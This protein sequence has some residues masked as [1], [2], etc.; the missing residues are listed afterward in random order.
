MIYNSPL[1]D[2]VIDR[3]GIDALFYAAYQAS[4]T[5]RG[6]KDI[7]TVEEEELGQEMC[8][9]IVEYLWAELAHKIYYDT[10]EWMLP[11][12]ELRDMAEHTLD[13]FNR[14]GAEYPN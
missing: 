10:G 6:P 13:V 5:I 11:A 3:I 14:Y 7:L 1:A 12:D 4:A 8:V 9:A 2:K